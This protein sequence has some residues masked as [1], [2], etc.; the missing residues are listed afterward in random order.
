MICTHWAEGGT[1]ALKLADALIAATEKPNNFHL[2]YDLE[3][4]IEDKI[5]KI[6]KEMY[7]AGQVV[8][9]EKVNKSCFFFFFYEII[10]KFLMRKPT[11]C[12]T[13]LIPSCVHDCV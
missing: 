3:S 8:L 10:Q 4:G 11:R 2:L 13:K 5:N 1:G 12:I 6:A 7:G 9:A